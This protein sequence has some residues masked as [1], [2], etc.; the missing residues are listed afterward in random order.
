MKNYEYQSQLAPYI[1]GL[2]RQKRADGYSYEFEAYML[3]RFDRFC[4]ENGYDNG[5]LTRE[6]VM[7]WAEQRP[8]ESK[9]YRNQR[10]SFV[11]QLALYVISLNMEAY[12]PRAFESNEISVPHILSFDEVHEFY[13]AVDNFLPCQPNF[14]RF[15]LSYSVLF[16]LFYCCGLRLS[17]G[18]YLKRSTVNLENGCLSIYQSKGHKDRVVFMSGDMLQMCRNY[19]RLMQKLLPDRD[20]F[21][22][23]R[24][25]FK[26]FSKTS[27][28]KKFSELWNMTPYAGKVDK[29]PTVH[30]LRHT[31]VVTKMN[32]WMKEGKDFEAMMPYLSRYLGHASID[33]TQY[34][35]HLVVFAFEIVRKHDSVAKRVI[36]EVV[37]HEE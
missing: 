23:G 19:D 26:P 2:I 10:V 22:P 28:D 25:E 7:A 33:E 30:S 17:E 35:Y 34:Y 29:K 9:N 8:S 27:I 37:P 32:D 18:C 16:R 15:S 21:F 31:Y 24:D 3:E 20:W 11:R 36:P 6:L 5:S 4:I 14:R 12:I 13:K 1:S